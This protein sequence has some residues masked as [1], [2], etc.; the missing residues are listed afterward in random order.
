MTTAANCPG[1]L[2]SNIVRDHCVYCDR[3]R[4]EHLKHFKKE[5]S[6]KKR[7]AGTPGGYRLRP[8]S[9]TRQLFEAELQKKEDEIS[10]LR[11]YLWLRH[12]CDGLYGDDG[13][14]QCN[15]CRIDFKRDS[16]R[17]IVERLD[18]I[19]LER[20]SRAQRSEGE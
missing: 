7:A 11:K 10:L 15:R 13:E 2:E 3:H 6:K 12:G 19:A 5:G 1:F 20:A 8:E 16:V 18:A 14:M 4:T 17:Q 9:E